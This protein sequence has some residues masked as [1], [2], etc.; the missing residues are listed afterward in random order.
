MPYLL[1]QAILKYERS[2]IL[3]SHTA[4]VVSMKR[5]TLQFNKAVVSRE[6]LEGLVSSQEVPSEGCTFNLLRSEPLELLGQGGRRECVRGFL[7]MMEDIR[8]QFGLYE[9]RE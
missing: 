4:F 9:A 5:T 2:P 3:N 6:Y 7:G 8:G 1:L